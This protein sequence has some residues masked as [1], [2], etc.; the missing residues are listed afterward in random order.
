MPIEFGESLTRIQ[1]KVQTCKWTKQ[2]E[3]IVV[4]Q[5]IDNE[6]LD[7]ISTCETND[8]DSNFDVGN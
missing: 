8:K 6:S 1:A 2:K 7:K 4:D 5:K 3:L